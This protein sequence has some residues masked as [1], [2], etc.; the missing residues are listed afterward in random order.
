M[1]SVHLTRIMSRKDYKYAE[2][3]N[4]CFVKGKNK[5]LPFSDKNGP[6][7][8]Q[9]RRLDQNRPKDLDLNLPRTT[10]HQRRRKRS[11]RSKRIPQ[12]KTSHQRRRKG[13]RKRKRHRRTKTTAAWWANRALSFRK[14]TRL[15][16]QRKGRRRKRTGWRLEKK[17][18]RLPSLWALM[19]LQRKRVR[20]SF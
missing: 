17:R 9:Q 19:Y 2:L 1:D 15:R 8:R 5:Y 11:T 3:Q 14:F 13:R 16:S 20:E 4:K 7:R 6:K 12:R 10:T 18:R